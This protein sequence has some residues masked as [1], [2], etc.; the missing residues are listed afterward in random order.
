MVQE[1]PS[2]DYQT[3]DYMHGD[4]WK[5]PK[6]DFSGRKIIFP[7]FLCGQIHSRHPDFARLIH[8]RKTEKNATI[9]G[10]STPLSIN[11]GFRVEHNL[12]PCKSIGNFVISEHAL[13]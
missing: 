6:Y 12:T 7:L 3:L 11:L 2:Q 8:V 1:M 10:V 9:Q 5:N 4:K 13:D